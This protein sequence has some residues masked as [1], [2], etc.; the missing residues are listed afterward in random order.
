MC[1]LELMSLNELDLFDV[2]G[3]QIL[4][5]EKL[6]CFSVSIRN[7]GGCLAACCLGR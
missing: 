2:H 1:I 6:A 5:E 7:T 4:E 3:L